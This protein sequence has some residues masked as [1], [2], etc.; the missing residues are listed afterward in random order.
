MDISDTTQRR[1]LIKLL[2]AEIA[3]LTASETIETHPVSA[4]AVADELSQTA[5]QVRPSDSGHSVNGRCENSARK[6]LL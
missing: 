5:V 1:H 3:R 4:P 6:R 2:E